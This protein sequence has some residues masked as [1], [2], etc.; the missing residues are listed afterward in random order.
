MELFY[1]IQIWYLKNVDKIDF[2]LIG[3]TLCDLIDNITYYWLKQSPLTIA[4]DI[5]FIVVILYL[6]NREQND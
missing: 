3:Y 5:I 2:F 1:K 6:R 4:W